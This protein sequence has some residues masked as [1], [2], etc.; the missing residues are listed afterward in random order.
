M[1]ANA[2]VEAVN[3]SLIFLNLPG[4]PLANVSS[5]IMCSI[6]RFILSLLRVS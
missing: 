6:T 4:F 3:I 1:V 2:Y 5:V